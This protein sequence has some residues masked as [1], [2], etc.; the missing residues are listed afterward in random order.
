MHV[1]YNLSPGADYQ[2][3]PYANRMLTGNTRMVLANNQPAIVGADGWPLGPGVVSFNCN[4]DSLDPNPKP[5]SLIML[6]GS[7]NSLDVNPGG[8]HVG[9]KFNGNIATFTSKGNPGG[10]ARFGISLTSPGKS[11]WV[12]VRDD[13]LDAY[14]ADP[15][16]FSPSYM[17]NR[18]W[19]KHIRF[20]DWLA[21]N[22]NRSDDYVDPDPTRP[23]AFVGKAALRHVVKYSLIANIQPWIPVP[24]GISDNNLRLFATQLSP[25]IVAGRRPKIEVG[26]EVWNEF[27]QW[28]HAYAVAQ[29]N[30]LIAAGKLPPDSKPTGMKWYGYRCTQISHI[31]Q[32]MGWR[33]GRDFDMVIGCFTNNP[34]QEALVWAGV[35][36]AGGVDAD[37]TRWSISSYIH[38]DFMADF[39][40]T[41]AMAK[42]GDA[43]VT[44]A[45]ETIKNGPVS[46]PTW[47][48]AKI[49]PFQAATA[50]KHNLVLD[51]YEGGT[52]FRFLPTFAASEFSRL[53]AGITQADLMAFVAKV[54]TDPRMFDVTTLNMSTCAN[55]GADVFYQYDDQTKW[56]VSGYWG[57]YGTPVWDAGMAW[58]AANR[59]KDELAGIYAELAALRTRVDAF[60]ATLG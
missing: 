19:I 49:L 59:S 42:A 16:A 37:F 30:T 29:E 51:V 17:A 36:A 6:Q 22:N 41:I 15:E 31:L 13:E 7:A 24:L 53:N 35:A 38:G 20:M 12:I 45:I 8:G 5:Y 14:R 21:T 2:A 54:Q 43:G 25:L 9:G 4:L 60:A 57:S 58:E 48:A 52:S 56:G 50:A 23:G 32:S 18:K 27:F 47:A 28:T 34:A 3:P 44:A 11:E 46:S 1:G 40:K 55:A 10:S 39:A 26:N 33:I